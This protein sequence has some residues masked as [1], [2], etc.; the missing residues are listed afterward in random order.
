MDFK[1]IKDRVEAEVE[2]H[3]ANKLLAGW[4]DD[5]VVI[6]SKSY[7][8]VATWEVTAEKDDPED[9]PDDYLETS[10][11]FDSDG[12]RFTSYVI[13]AYGQIVFAQDGEYKVVY[14]RLPDPLER[15][16]DG[17]VE[18]E[19]EP[20]VHKIFHMDLITGCIAKYWDWESLGDRAESAHGSKFWASF[21]QSVYESARKLR[22]REHMPKHI[23]LGNPWLFGIGG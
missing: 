7:G 18:D 17:E 3:V 2:D 10:E 13:N 20:P 12:K 4:V 6:I 5:L 23:Q 19:E 21:Y 11:I 22:E 14:Y 8:K 15:N 16:V 9:L 1:Y